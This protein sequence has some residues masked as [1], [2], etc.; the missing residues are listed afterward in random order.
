M[1]SNFLIKIIRQQLNMKAALA[2]IVLFALVATSMATKEM[3]TADCSFDAAAAC[4]SEIGAAWDGCTGFSNAEEILA[5]MEGIIGASDCWDCV[6]VVLSF[7][8]FCA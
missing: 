6:C 1:G 5:C 3:R 4:V 2:S 8:P 7:L